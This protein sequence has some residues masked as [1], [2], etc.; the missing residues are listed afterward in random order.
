MAEPLI[1]AT[2][3]GSWPFPGWYEKFIAD[4]KQN[5]DQFGAHDRDE[6]VSD[7][8]R[9]AIFDQLWAGLDRITD[10]E[11]QRV[12]FNLGFYQHIRG[13]EP[14]PP[15][16]RWGA[17]AHDQRDHYRAVAPLEAS[18]GL[19][20]TEEYARLR[21]HTDRPTKVPVP[22][23]FTLAGCIDG[24]DIYPDR[25]AV[26]A[27]LSRSSMRS[28]RHSWRPESISFSS[29]NP[30]SLAIPRHADA[31]LDIIEQTVAGVDAYISMHMCFGNYRARAVGPSFI[32]PAF[33]TPWPGQGQ[34]ARAR[35]CQ[36][37]NGRDRAPGRIARD[38]GRRGGAGGRQEYLGRA[39]RAGGRAIADG[40][41]VCRSRTSFGYS[42][43]RLFPDG[44]SRCG[45]QGRCARRWRGARTQ[46]AQAMIEPVCQ[47][48]ELVGELERSVPAP[49]TLHVWW[50]GQSGFLLKSRTGLL[51]IDLYLSDHLTAKYAATDR[52]HV[53]MTRAPLQGSDLHKVDLVLAS[54]KHSDHLDPGTL[55]DLMESSSAILVIPEAIR[56]HALGLGLAEKRLVGLD[57]GDRIEKAGFSIRAIPSAHESLDTDDHGRHLYLGFVIES[58]GL[59][60][61]HSGDSV[62]YTRPAR[63]AR[64]RAI[65]RA[66]SADQRP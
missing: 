48:M 43:L 21:H 26:T 32:P 37:R 65:R 66:V 29:T 11:M 3:I 52:P 49:G 8:V 6:A 54:H 22:G 40:A 20:T 19:G 42:R 50:L 51:A 46:R 59:R 58:E 64:A 16:R 24:G 28:S 36:P 9:L 14:V 23:P 63:A 30:A 47:G 2:V 12:D 53:R 61:Y 57:A 27:A 4:V 15:A 39:G 1:P 35:I 60:L 44:P 31:F 17:P 33:P 55:P 56:E 45:R 5:P 34:S 7:A 25:N 62:V 13:I 38:H 18:E 41:R 10:G